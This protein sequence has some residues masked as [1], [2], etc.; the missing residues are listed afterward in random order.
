MKIYFDES[1]NSGC[2]LR[3]EDILNFATQPTFAVGAVFV[4]SEDDEK[5]LVLK[6]KKFK[7]K[8]GIVE[9][10]KGSEM[11]TRNRNEELTYFL[12]NILD[13]KHFYII[14]YD[15]RFYITTL[16]LNSIAGREFQQN[17]PVCFI[18]KLVP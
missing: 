5:E 3:N 9:P 12:K 2:V 18:N 10:I 17:Y 15:K 6:Y 13:D 11:L 1:G 4:D 14:L 7:K 16:F 8:F